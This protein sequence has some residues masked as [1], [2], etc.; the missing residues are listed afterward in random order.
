MKSSLFVLLK[1]SIKFIYFPLAVIYISGVIGCNHQPSKSYQDVG[2]RISDTLKAQNP[3]LYLPP[4][5]GI[6]ETKDTATSF[7][8]STNDVARFDNKTEEKPYVN[9]IQ[10]VDADEPWPPRWYVS[11]PYYSDSAYNTDTKDGFYRYDVVV[12]A[13]VD[14]GLFS[15]YKI[16]SKQHLGI[17]QLVSPDF[18]G[19]I[20]L[21]EKMEPIDTIS[22]NTE[23]SNLYFHDLRINKKGERM[24]DLKKDMY[25]NLTKR[26]GNAKDTAVHCNVDFIHIMGANKKTLYTWNPLE[27]VDGDLFNFKEAVKR[28][29][30]AANH[31]D[32]LEWTRLTSALWDYDGNILYAMRQIGI[33]KASIKTGRVLWQINTKDMPFVSGKD[34]LEW[35]SPHDFNLLW[36][37]ATTATY[38]LFSDGI[39]N[40][41]DICGVVFQYNKKNKQFKIVKYV[42]AQT[43]LWSN[44]QGN[45]DIQTNGDY[46][47]GYGFFEPSDSNIGFRNVFE[48]RKTDG[49]SNVYQ[50]PVHNYIYKARILK[51]WPRPTRPI[52]TRKGV[53]LEVVGDLT[54]ITWYKLSGK[55][56]RTVEKIAKG[57]TL[58]AEKG[59][60]YCVEAKYGIG[61]VVSRKFT[62]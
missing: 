46:A 4:V 13:K 9:S 31:S 6:F 5:V 22:S 50:L 27:H 23:K 56:N 55:G 49:F 61:Y 21:N 37:D 47:M 57:K 35:Y 54:E 14:F 8:I 2:T 12:D 45:L 44:G 1:R 58:K 28:K 34:T 19:Y 16:I 17:G 43:K 33:G 18:A 59:R 32:L 24:V 15:F 3:F 38:S 36:Q 48:Y 26:T 53:L 42:P 52:I 60:T 7:I 30:F 51:N 40:E 20:L 62:F 25:L 10:I 39:Q 41:K 29:A 11:T